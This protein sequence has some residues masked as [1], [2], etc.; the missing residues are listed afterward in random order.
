MKPDELE[1]RCFEFIARGA[2][3]DAAHDL[4]HVKRVVNNTLYLTDIEQANR[5]IT[6]PAACLH[7]CVSVPKNSPLRS[8]GS[9]LAAEAA[10]AFLGEIAYAPEL[11]PD[12]AHAI[13]AHSFSANIPCRTLEAKVVQDADRMDAL[14]AIGI[15]RCL[16]VGGQFGLPLFNPDDP[17]C[18][19]REPDEKS[20]TI[21]HFYT[22]LFKLPGTMQTQAG[23]V[24]AERRV[25][26]MRAYLENLAAE[27]L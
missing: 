10:T 25:D 26:L 14:G 11:I 9:R 3:A 22:K 20:Y 15:A 21:D 18:E 4:S 24:E 13:E 6:L 5:E 27:I 2:P 19:H 12:I 1:K 8:Q 16:A 17:F 23:R 7:D